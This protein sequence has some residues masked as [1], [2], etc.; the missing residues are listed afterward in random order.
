MT[1]DEKLIIE[2]TPFDALTVMVIISIFEKK[3]PED[4]KIRLALA[5]YNKEIIK[6]ISPEQMSEAFIEK[7]IYEALLKNK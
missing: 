1:E 3:L 7:E 6:K 2:L 5:N 4:D